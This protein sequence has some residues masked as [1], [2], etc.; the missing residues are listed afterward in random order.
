METTKSLEIIES[1]LKESRKS[2]HRN[3]FYFILWGI[4]L[5]PAAIY[6]YLMQGSDNYWIV[7]PIVGILGGII[8]AIY[9][10]RED[11]KSGVST[12]GDRITNYTWGAFGF[13]LVFVIAFSIYNGIP[14]QALIL[15]LAGS[16][17]FISGGISKFR[18]FVWGGIILEAGAI[19]C[20][21]VLD[22]EIHSL[23]FAASILAGYVIPGF[24]LRKEEHGQA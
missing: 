3:S 19:L 6:E 10:K 20:A 22:P 2:L 13:G 9:G 1:M 7:W 14:P 17:T 12:S 4:L 24:I 23:V 5:I 11:K 21:F 15:M 8:S 16:A 18:P